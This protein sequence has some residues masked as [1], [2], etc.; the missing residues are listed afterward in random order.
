MPKLKRSNYSKLKTKALT[1][2]VKGKNIFSGKCWYRIYEGKKI[3]DWTLGSELQ[4]PRKTKIK[5]QPTTRNLSIGTRTFA[6]RTSGR[7]ADDEKT[8]QKKKITQRQTKT[9]NKRIGSQNR[10]IC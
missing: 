8:H 9:K 1:T 2:W 6:A 7:H 5:F 3:I 10:W 4:H